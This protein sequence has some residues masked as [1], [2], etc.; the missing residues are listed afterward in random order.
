MSN[1]SGRRQEG[2]A[3]LV[4]VLL[5]A[6]MGV[7]G[8]SSMETVMRDRQISGFQ[9]RSET[10]LY[11]ADA[12]VSKALA[13]IRQD[14]PGLA[15][16]GEAALYDYN[17]NA[18]DPPLFP[19]ENAPASLGGSDFPAPGSPTY[20]MDPDAGDPNDASAA[21]Q[22]IRYIGK[23]DVCPGWVMSSDEASVEWSEAMWDIRVEGSNPGGTSVAIQATGTNCHPYN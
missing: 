11:A 16:G 1:R 19:E 4:A 13:L 20:Y 7:I 5:L 22:A 9:K 21:P 8:L 17:P 3:L 6:L 14:A 2:A 10:A 15:E 12:G 23:G 18:P